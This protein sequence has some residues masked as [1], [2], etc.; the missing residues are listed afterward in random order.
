M[1]WGLINNRDNFVLKFLHM[2][3]HNL[4]SNL[5]FTGNIMWAGNEVCVVGDKKYTKYTRKFKILYRVTNHSLD[6]NLSLK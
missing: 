4:H 6:S 5:F 2:L 3:L 1:T